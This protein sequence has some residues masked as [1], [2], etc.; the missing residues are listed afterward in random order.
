MIWGTEML[1]LGLGRAGPLGGES[2]LGLTGRCSR[3][4]GPGSRGAR[5]AAS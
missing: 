1:H 5:P 4:G 2:G 3:A